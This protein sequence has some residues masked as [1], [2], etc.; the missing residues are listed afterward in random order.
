[1]DSNIRCYCS[2][3][4]FFSIGVVERRWEDATTATNFLRCDGKLEIRYSDAR[5]Q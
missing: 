5:K 2:D 4:L 1:V 3:I